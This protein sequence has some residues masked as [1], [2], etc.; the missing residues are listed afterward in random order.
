M[1]IGAAMS[2]HQER[3]GT[4]WFEREVA[5]LQEKLDQDVLKNKHLFGY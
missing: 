2:V 5:A 3:L 1:E 4:F